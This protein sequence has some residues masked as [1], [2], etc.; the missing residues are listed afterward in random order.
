MRLRGRGIFYYAW[1]MGKRAVGGGG[2]P[3]RIVG[4]DAKFKKKFPARFRNGQDR[5]L[6]SS[7]KWAM[8]FVMHL[9][10]RGAQC[11][12]AALQKMMR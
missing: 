4:V 12:P 9:T 2:E 10:R 7:L 8:S 1:A 5:S 11:A 6:Q 3:K